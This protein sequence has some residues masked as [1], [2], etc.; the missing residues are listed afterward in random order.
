MNFSYFN[1]ITN[2]LQLGTSSLFVPKVAL[3]ALVCHDCSCLYSSLE[4]LSSLYNLALSDCHHRQLSKPPVLSLNKCSFVF[5]YM[6]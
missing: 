1:I 2:V 6:I 5:S 3:F 4:V